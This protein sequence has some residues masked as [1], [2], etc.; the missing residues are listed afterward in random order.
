MAQVSRQLEIED[1]IGAIER[2]GAWKWMVQ[3]Y[4]PPCPICP[5]CKEQITGPRALATF[6]EMG[7]VYCKSC[8]STFTPTNGTPIHETSWSPEE[9]VKLMLLL[10]ADRS[11]SEIAATLGKSSGAIKDMRE[12]IALRHQTAS[13]CPADTAQG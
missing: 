4:L 3:T 12:R 1:L 5:S 13:S 9:Y 11:H 6:W 7:R 8:G 10:N 2:S